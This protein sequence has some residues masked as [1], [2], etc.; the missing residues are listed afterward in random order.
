[1]QKQSTKV[2]TMANYRVIDWPILVIL[3]AFGLGWG[4]EKRQNPQNCDRDEEHVSSSIIAVRKPIIVKYV[5]N[6]KSSGH[7]DAGCQLSCHGKISSTKL[8]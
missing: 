6:K 7:F 2:A 5:Y 1:M 8:L 4:S 3:L